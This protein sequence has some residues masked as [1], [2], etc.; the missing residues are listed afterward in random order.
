MLDVAT[1]TLWRHL[2]SFD[3]VKSMLT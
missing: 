1:I 3:F 2:A